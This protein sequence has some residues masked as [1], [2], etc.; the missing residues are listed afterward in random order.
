[1]KHN[2]NPDIEGVPEQG[3]QR[4]ALRDRVNGRRYNHERAKFWESTLRP[5]GNHTNNSHESVVD[6][7]E[8]QKIAYREAKDP[9]YS[10]GEGTK[11]VNDPDNAVEKRK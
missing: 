10:K 1:M 6:N 2:P 4:Q 5:D 3:K 9:K 11:Y 8:A 7:K